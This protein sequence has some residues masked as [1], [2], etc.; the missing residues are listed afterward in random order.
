MSASDSWGCLNLS[1][2][3][4]LRERGWGPKRLSVH[5][6][7][8]NPSPGVP[9]EGGVLSQES[10]ALILGLDANKKSGL[11]AHFSASARGRAHPGR[12]PVGIHVVWPVVGSKPI[13]CFMENV[14]VTFCPG[15][16]DSVSFARPII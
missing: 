1:P 11:Q 14:M 5:G 15:R 6:L 10:L 13:I 7:T 12:Q 2:L 9:G 3:P 8:P 4:V 16:N